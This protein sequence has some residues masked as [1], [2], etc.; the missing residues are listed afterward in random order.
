MPDEVISESEARIL[1]MRFGGVSRTNVNPIVPSSL[2]VV[3]GG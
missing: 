2:M 1:R 3:M